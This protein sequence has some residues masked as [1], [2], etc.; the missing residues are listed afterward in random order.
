M[1]SIWEA[2]E[3]TRTLQPGKQDGR[4]LQNLER[5]RESQQ[6]MAVHC[7]SHK[8][9]AKVTENAKKKKLLMQYDVKN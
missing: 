9:W 8:N 3:H 2:S 5:Y 6:E 4:V 1:P 7:S